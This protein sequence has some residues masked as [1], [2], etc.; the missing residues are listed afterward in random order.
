VIACLADGE[1]CVCDLGTALGLSPAL[2]S[3]HL[4]ALRDSGL[5]RERRAGRW[6]YYSLD[7]DRLESFGLDRSAAYTGEWHGHG[8]VGLRLQ[9]GDRSMT[10]RLLAKLEDFRLLPFFVVISMAIGIGIGKALSISDF[11][12]TPPIDAIKAIV[13]W[14]VHPDR[15]Q[16]HLAGSADRALRDDVPGDDERATGEVG[17]AFRS[18]RQLG[19]GSCSTTG[20]AVRD[21]RAGQRLRERP[22]TP[23]RPRPVRALPRAS[24]W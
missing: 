9:P 13:R 8:S 12:L 7:R 6:V 15:A 22:G 17:A 3:H 1:R 10:A 24:R 16:C 21:A 4:R 2:A 5:I 14:N 20:G 18:P 19:V 23:H 11:T